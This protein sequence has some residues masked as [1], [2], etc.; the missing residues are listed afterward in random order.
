M[1]Y[2]ILLLTVAFWPTPVDRPFE[3]IIAR[4]IVELHER[5]VPAFVG[6]GLIEFSAN[7]ALFVPAG[8]MFGLLLPLRWWPVMFLTGP[9]L[10]LV[11]EIAQALFLSARYATA[12]DVLANSMGAA[13]GVAIA[14]AA[15]WRAARRRARSSAES[16][17]GVRPSA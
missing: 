10:S 2:G 11:V 9:V 5:G 8:L 12:S 16:D 15:R 7:I 13:L 14:L 4:I 6:Y 1:L 17:P 3:R